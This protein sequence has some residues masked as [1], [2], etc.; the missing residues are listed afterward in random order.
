MFLPPGFPN[1]SRTPRAL[2]TTVKSYAQRFDALT[3]EH[4]QSLAALAE[5]QQEEAKSRARLSAN[6]ASLLQRRR[7]MDATNAASSS[8]AFE[9]AT[10]NR[11]EINQLRLQVAA[12]CVKLAQH[13]TE[14]AESQQAVLTLQT[15][16][17]SSRSELSECLH[18][19]SEIWEA[20]K[21]QACSSNPLADIQP[22]EIGLR[23]CLASGSAELSDSS[24]EVLGVQT[25]LASGLTQEVNQSPRTQVYN[26]T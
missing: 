1:C 7:E 2:P 4:A 23:T 22:Q 3:G 18:T 14:L 16:L 5:S 20:Q 26:I 19:V 13:Q 17:A 21:Q 11:Q 8:L 9:L 15:Q 10:A 12:G 6:S 25:Q 24:Q